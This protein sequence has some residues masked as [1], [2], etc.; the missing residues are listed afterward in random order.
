[1]TEAAPLLAVSELTLAGADG[2]PFLEDITFAIGAGEVLGLSGDSGSGKSLLAAAILGLLPPAVR[3]VR[4]SIKFRGVPI[5]GLREHERHALRGQGISAIVQDAQ[6]SLDPTRRIGH[7]IE[8]TLRLLAGYEGRAAR[9]AADQWLE[10]VGL[11][12]AIRR[13]HPHQLSG[14]QAQRVVAALALAP[15]PALLLAD[16]PTSALDVQNAQRMVGLLRDY[17]RAHQCAVLLSSHDDAVLRRADRVAWLQARRLS[18]SPSPVLSATYSFA[19]RGPPGASAGAVV[20]LQGVRHVYRNGMRVTVAL[21]DV[22]FEI[23]ARQ[24]LALLG[25]SGSGKST[26]ARVAAGLIRPSSGSVIRP[27][28]VAMVFQDARE[29]FDPRWPVLRSVEEPVRHSLSRKDARTL[30]AQAVARV[31]LSAVTAA[32]LPHTLSGG[33]LQR[34]ALA[35]A[36]VS[37]PELLVCDEPTSALDARSRA[38]I[39]A[40]LQD[41]QRERG[42]AML[43]VTHDVVAA[44]GVADRAAVLDQGRLV[45]RGP[46]ADILGAVA[47]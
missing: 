44:R 38:D 5:E 23:A 4:G 25:E 35:R 9:A 20:R 47:A 31:G 8:E 37:D 13:R 2:T 36:L 11:P 34:G 45:A 7:Q 46:A 10:R 27:A 41:L 28:R 30:A 3:V 43:F 40:L 19:P 1:M 33:E 21:D 18:V 6:S 16:E 42:F 39:L 15:S 32:R 14:G 12:S 22:S 24:T 26:V 17:V 29:A